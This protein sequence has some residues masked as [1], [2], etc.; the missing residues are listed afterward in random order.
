MNFEKIRNSIFGPART[1]LKEGEIIAV[2]GATGQQGGAVARELLAHGHRVRA[3]TRKPGSPKALELKKLGAEIIAADFRDTKG[4]V[5][6]LRGAWGAF[7]VQNS[8]DGGVKAEVENGINFANAARKAGVDHFVYTSV[9]SAD[10]NTGIPHFDSKRKIERHI[11]GLG[12]RSSVVLRPVFFMENWRSELFSDELAQG[13]VAIALRPET[14]LQM[15][16]LQDIGVFGR[17]AFERW[18]ELNGRYIELAG[19]ER[20]APDIAQILSDAAKKSFTYKSIPSD[21]L[22]SQ[23]ADL[24]LMFSWFDR[25]GYCGHVASLGK[26]LEHRPMSLAEWAAIQK[27]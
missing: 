1:G 22:R 14:K 8:W 6:S 25:V 27:W 9:G 17:I 24:A 18:E 20:S 11:A 26:E 15:I 7:S 16:S 13:R 10:R 23:S 12:F 3:L 5:Q 2:S 4:L 21:V 19:D